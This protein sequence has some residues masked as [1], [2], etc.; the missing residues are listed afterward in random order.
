MAVPQKRKEPVLKYMIPSLERLIRVLEFLAGEQSPR[1]DR[2][3]QGPVGKS[4][5]QRVGA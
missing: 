2:D 1:C 3:L 5:V 4:V